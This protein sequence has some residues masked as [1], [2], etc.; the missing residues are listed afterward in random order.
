MAT[1]PVKVRYTRHTV[2]YRKEKGRTPP[3]I[4]KPCGEIQ[5]RI[6]R[7]GLKVLY[8][9]DVPDILGIFCNGAV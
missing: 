8:L 6:T 7:S 4:H 3:L 5:S 2:H 1:F 9:A